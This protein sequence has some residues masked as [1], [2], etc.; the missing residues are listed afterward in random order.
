MSG[1]AA[2][3]YPS[4]YE[5]FGLAPLEAMACGA[6]VVASNLASLPEVGG[7]GGLLVDDATP[8]A[9]MRA[10]ETTLRDTSFARREAALAQAHRFDWDEAT[11]RLQSLLNAVIRGQR[12]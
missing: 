11:V 3:V 9:W 12:P 7:A 10:L 2:F 1:A 6:P 5:G 8:E 4:R